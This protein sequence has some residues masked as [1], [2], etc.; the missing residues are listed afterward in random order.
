[1]FPEELMAVGELD[2]KV[3]LVFPEI[4]IWKSEVV[5]V[6]D[7]WPLINSV[8]TVSLNV[9]LTVRLSVEILLDDTWGL[10]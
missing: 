8:Y 1:M 6:L 9:K 4:E 5:R 2:P 3:I 7:P 10:V